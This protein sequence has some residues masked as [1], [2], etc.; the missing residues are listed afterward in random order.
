MMND[1]TRMCLKTFVPSEQDVE[2]QKFERKVKEKKRQRTRC[3]ASYPYGKMPT[4]MTIAFSFLGLVTS[5]LAKRSTSFLVLHKSLAPLDIIYIPTYYL[6]LYRIQLCT[7]RVLNE[8]AVH[9]E[10]T[11]SYTDHYYNSTNADQI[12]RRELQDINEI[13]FRNESDC[14]IVRLSAA[15]VRDKF[16]SLARFSSALAALCG[17]VVFS[18]SVVSCCSSKVNVKAVG[19]LGLVTYLF[20]SRKYWYQ[21]Y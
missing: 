6:G 20:E 14:K 4:F 16:W 7:G 13:F 8:S 17:I 18:W 5:L 12:F 19:F 9:G 21:C 1:A 15:E 10:H 11:L 3:Y 2:K